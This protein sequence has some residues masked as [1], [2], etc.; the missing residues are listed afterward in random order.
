MSSSSAAAGAGGSASSSSA[1][2][3]A[4]PAAAASAA[5][6]AARRER[7]KSAAALEAEIAAF[8]W[9]PAAF[10]LVSGMFIAAALCFGV[11][12]EGTAARLAS[13]GLLAIFASAFVETH[14]RAVFCEAGA[15]KL[16]AAEVYNALARSA[17]AESAATRD[18]EVALLPSDAD[19]AAAVAPEGDGDAAS[20]PRT[21]SLREWAADAGYG[22]IPGTVLEAVEALFDDAGEAAALEKGDEAERQEQ[23][24]SDAA[25]RSDDDDGG[26]GADKAEEGATRAA[27]KAAAK[28]AAKA[29]SAKKKRRGQGS[30][31]RCKNSRRRGG[32]RQRPTPSRKPRR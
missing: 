32:R 28:A 14:L 13:A 5:P 3:A 16:A 9:T 30:A 2:S 26:G 4:A 8:K 11:P 7:K 20:D 10:A 6:L 23:E 24:Q 22:D 27:S 19:A 17:A 31:Q 15:G 1:A 12:A 25:D 29:A 18:S 21:R